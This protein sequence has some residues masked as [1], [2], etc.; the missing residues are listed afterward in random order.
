MDKEYGDIDSWIGEDDDDYCYACDDWVEDDGHGNCNTCGV[1]FTS[2]DPFISKET[3]LK[4]S[5]SSTKVN[6]YTGDMWNRGGAYTWG[7]GQSWW[8]RGVSGITDRMSPM[9]SMWGGSWS[10]G[11]STDAGRMLRHKRHLD[12][13][14]KVVDPT[15]KHTLDFAYENGRNYSNIANG[16]IV[17]DGSLIKDSDDNL[18]ICAGLSIH[19]KLHLIHTQPC[20]DWEKEYQLEHH[21]TMPEQKLLHNIVNIIED[22][23]IEKQLSK[24]CAG[25]VS[26]IDKVKEHFFENNK[27]LISKPHKDE[28]LDVINTLLAFVRYPAS[29]DKD[30]RK[31]HAKH[32]RYFA[33]AL[34]HGLDDRDSTY[35]AFSS[36]F[37]Y[38][39]AL[40]EELAPD[41]EEAMKDK[42][43]S[44]MKEIE[45]RLGDML[46]KDEMDKVREQMKKDLVRD[47]MKKG[48]PLQRAMYDDGHMDSIEGMAD[49]TKELESELDK[50][51]ADAIKELEDSDYHETTLG[52]DKVLYP[53]QTKVTWRTAMPNEHEKGVYKTEVKQMKPVINSLKKK[54]NLYG[55]TQKYTI[56]NQKR[57]KLDKRVLHRIPMGSRELF[58]CDFSKEDK[59]LDICILVDESGSMNS[60]WRMTHARQSAIAI[61]EAL[62]DNPKLNLW[63]YGHTADGYDDWHSD[64]G[65]TN[66]TQYWGPSMKDRPMAM[67]GMKARFENRDGNAIWSCADK[68]SK[69]SDQPMSNKLMI[70]LSDGQPAAHRYGGDGA[71]RHVKGIVREL[72]S[73]GWSIIQIGFGGATDYYMDKMF[74]NYMHISDTKDIPNKLSK[75]MKR[76]MKL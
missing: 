28:F 73:K 19:E 67:G 33:K 37:Q 26:Y 63:V 52:K 34:Q 45:D 42:L 43:E 57:G 1:S 36:I 2:V 9:T 13:L 51:L 49:Y 48:S 55:N 24:D 18:D 5:S 75:V 15:V 11:H 14:C 71:R 25:F 56:R 4:H 47:M 41:D 68:V 23:Y 8:Q 17:I 21:L 69:E 70:V 66:M 72:E 50:A 20:K 29:I 58:K 40:C 32:I 7:S 65:S 35:K 44:A 46:S 31:R 6:T 12:S 74:N 30:R 3:A 76:V 22:E 61:K 27:D 60:G 59:P 16:R 64:K 62:A 38:M 53:K 39:K 10:T 54:I